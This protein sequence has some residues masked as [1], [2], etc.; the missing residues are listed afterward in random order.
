MLNVM[1]KFLGVINISLYKFRNLKI[2]IVGNIKE[3]CFNQMKIKKFLFLSVLKVKIVME[4]H[5]YS[6]ILKLN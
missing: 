1:M 5:S 6:K 2:A 3:K 4:E